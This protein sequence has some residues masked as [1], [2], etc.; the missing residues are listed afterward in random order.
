MKMDPDRLRNYDEIVR[1][2]RWRELQSDDL[3]EKPSL[4]DGKIANSPVDL[5]RGIT[6]TSSNATLIAPYL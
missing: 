1:G 2:K 4:L 3:V 5:L 6:V